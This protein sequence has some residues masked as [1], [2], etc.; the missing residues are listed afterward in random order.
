MVRKIK[1]ACNINVAYKLFIYFYYNTRLYAT[2]TTHSL[3]KINIV[4]HFI[5]LKFPPFTPIAPSFMI[6]II[7][8][9]GDV[10]I[11]IIQTYM[12]KILNK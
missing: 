9:R 1:E 5:Y 8:G 2:Q 11:I 12:K 4:M 6:I 3:A 10:K 7:I